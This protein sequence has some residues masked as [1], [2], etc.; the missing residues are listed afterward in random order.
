MSKEILISNVLPKLKQLG[1]NYSIG[2]ETDVSIECEF[3]SAGWSTGKKKINY[4][5]SV[6]FDENSQTIFM[7]ELTK[8]AGAG[9]SF[10]GEGET[11][12]QSGK[13]FF[14][15]VKSIQYGPDGKAYEYNLD[16]GAIP[17]AF[18]EVAK[19]NNWKFKTVLR[20]EKACYPQGDNCFNNQ[21]FSQ[22]PSQQS[23]RYNEEQF[24]PDI[25]NDMTQN[26]NQQYNT[27]Q[28]N[29]YGEVKPNVK[30][31]KKPILFWML[32]VFFVLLDLLLLIGGSGIWFFVLALIPLIVT[33]VINRFISKSVW[34]TILIFVGILLITFIIFAFTATVDTDESK[35][36]T[37]GDNSNKAA[38]IS[39]NVGDI[40]KP[41]IVK[42]GFARTIEEETLKPIETTTTFTSEDNYIYYSLLLKY[43]SANTQITANWYYE[44]KLIFQTEPTKVES[45]VKNQYYTT[46]LQRGEK[47]LPK[48]SYKVEVI[49]T[50]DNNEIYKTTDSF[51][52]K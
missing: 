30:M 38:E 51:T 21:E 34:K 44:D 5:A 50:K 46:H 24:N 1:I 35:N 32:F 10:G 25:Q 42:A 19:E 29:Y 12:F 36:T 43:L 33:A 16:L 11:S 15:K 48:G 20:K 3:V 7:W 37:S 4:Y 26:N 27:S 2:Q 17:K 22:E 31:N 9:F 52:V 49:I 14:R 45:D 47:P 40:N 41:D 39:V 8:E 28:G 13:T 23:I 6:F 18:K